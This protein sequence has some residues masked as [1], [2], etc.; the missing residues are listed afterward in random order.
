[1]ENLPADLAAQILSLHAGQP[2][3]DAPIA[4]ITQARDEWLKSLL[5]SVNARNID[6][7]RYDA[8]KRYV[9]KFVAWAGGEKNIRT[10]DDRR[11][12][13][14]WAHLGV[15][16]AEGA[17]KPTTAHQAL[18]TSKQ[19]I[20]WCA[21]KNLLPAPANIT[22]KRLRIKIPVKA[23]ETFTVKEVR[24]LL[25]CDGSE[26]AK[27]FVLLMLNCGMLQSDISDLGESEVDWHKG[28]ITRPRSKRS[29]GVVTRYMLSTDTFELLQKYRAKAK[30][31]N[32]RGDNRVLLT[33]RGT[34]LVSCW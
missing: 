13:E 22:D 17:M 14:W 23:V 27:L 25:D 30:V 29:E 33:E 11:L 1:M 26:R 24:A 19:F 7:S 2:A 3:E 31:P 34:P 9:E 5:M 28:I 20:R 4:T 12:E 10:I 6:I 21:Q 15:R 18:M 32:E 8:Y 16:I